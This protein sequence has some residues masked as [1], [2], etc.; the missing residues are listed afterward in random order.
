M[1]CCPF[2][3]G[4]KCIY[5]C[6]A[7]PAPCELKCAFGLKAEPFPCPTCECAPDPCLSKTCASNEKC[8]ARLH[9]PCPIKDACGW[10]AQ[11]V[12]RTPTPTTSNPKPKICPLYWPSA[13]DSF[14]S[15]VKCN[16]SDASC[17]SNQKCC[18]GPRDFR[19]P[20]SNQTYCT[21]P[22]DD[23]SSCSLDCPLGRQI[24]YACEICQCNVDPCITATC[25]TN[26]NCYPI[27]APCYHYP[28]SPP[29]PWIPSCLL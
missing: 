17:P 9:E 2:I 22:C 28:G 20:D 24:P 10:T 4:M 5:P 21:D 1:K 18:Q 13:R 16:G 14:S 19:G 12:P 11:C 3:T 25:R 6:P 8:V 26:R 27:S 15:L 7:L 23:I 29:C